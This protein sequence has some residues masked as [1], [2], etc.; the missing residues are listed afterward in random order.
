V[1]RRLPALS[2]AALA[3]WL[4]TSVAAA[5][6]KPPQATQAELKRWLASLGSAGV[7]RGGAR[8]WRYVFFAPVTPPLEAVSIELV[9]AGYAVAGL[10]AAA[11]GAVLTVERVELHG[12]ATLAARNR[13]LAAL[14]RRHGARY[15]GVDVA[16]TR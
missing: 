11:G 2:I 15:D 9:G 13:E 16:S 12:A 4:L 5:A 1:Q 3:A 7:E 6:P 14:A 8:R 10:G